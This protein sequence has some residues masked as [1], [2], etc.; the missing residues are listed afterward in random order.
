M[1]VG[2]GDHIRSIIGRRGAMEF[3][4]LAIKPGKPVGV[5]DIDDCPIL[6]LPGN[7]IAAVVAFIAVGRPMVDVVCGALHDPPQSLSIPAAFTLEKRS[8]VRQFLL[9]EV[10]A[11]DREES[12]VAPS[13]RQGTA[14]LSALTGSDGFIVLNE[15][16]EVV[17]RGERVDFLP[18][19]AY[20]S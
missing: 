1:S 5:G 15:D 19:Q 11:R 16:R 9:A 7:P 20:L 10:R 12:A 13:N 6:A 14:M 18:M 17:R 2:S 8:G 4:P 3:W